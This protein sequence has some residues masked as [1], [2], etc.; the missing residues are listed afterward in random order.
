M[1]VAIAGSGDLARYLVEEFRRLDVPVVILCRTKKNHFDLP[2]VAQK[3]VDY[4]SVDSLAHA[5]EGS[6][7]LISMILDYTMAFKDAHLKLIAACHRSSTCRRFIPAEYGPD[8]A[9]YPDQPGFQYASHEPVRDALREQEEVEWTLICCG[10]LADYVL[11]VRNRYIK[12]IGDAPF[13]LSNQRIVIP[14]T[15]KEKVDV[16]S[17]RDLCKALVAL[18]K[19]PAGSWEPYTYVSGE[20]TTLRRMAEQVKTRY[21]SMKF[22]THF[23]SLNQLVNAVREAKTPEERIEAE[24]G[25]VTL[26]SNGGFDSDV[27]DSQRRKFFKGI[28]FR[29]VQELLDTLDN[30]PEIIV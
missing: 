1:T 23:I 6:V 4:G 30:D 17:A 9:D 13:N 16:I 11:P 15:G 24:F 3:V 25:I 8:I 14:R 29:S 27:V 5:L 10:W 20:K 12:D 22:D 18:T 26:S 21:A 2:G 28:H 19:A 7:A